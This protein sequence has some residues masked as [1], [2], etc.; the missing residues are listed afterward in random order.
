MKRNLM[1]LG[2]E[3]GV[4]KTTISI[5]LCRYLKKQKYNIVPFKSISICTEA[6]KNISGEYISVEQFMQAE[7]CEI[8]PKGVL[9]PVCIK[10]DSNKIFINGKFYR[11]K[12]NFKSD[13]LIEDFKSFIKEDFEKICEEYEYRIIE[14]N[15]ALSQNEYEYNFISNNFTTELTE[16]DIILVSDNE[17]GGAIPSLYGTLMLIDE[18]IKGKIKGIIINK[19]KD[20]TD[21][22]K[23]QI[24]DFEKYSNIPIL[25]VIPYKNIELDKEKTVIKKI[26]STK[27]SGLNIAIVKLDNISNLT[28]FYPLELEKNIN[29]RYVS[30]E[31]EIEGANLI[32]IPGSKSPINDLNKLK[33]SGMYNKII[34]LHKKGATVMGICS[35]FQMLGKNLI[36]TEDNLAIE[37]FDMIPFNTKFSLN[38]K[39][40]IAKGIVCSM[41]NKLKPLSNIRIYGYEIQNGYSEMLDG[42]EVFII[43]KNNNIV[44]LSN[45][46]GDVFGTYI[47]G[48][49]EIE[50]FRK[51]LINSLKEKYDVIIENSIEEKEKYKM[52]RLKQ[53]DTLTE[54]IENN[55]DLDKVKGFFSKESEEIENKDIELE[56]TKDK[57]EVR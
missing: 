31:S 44:G 13:E 49:F 1:F 7:A 10:E 24:R 39:T 38:K 48:I 18:N 2:T 22:L 55:I 20:T 32:I 42:G 8:E 50:A 27:R 25:G 14:G 34:D 30:S 3:S 29:I 43:D 35:G 4:G 51:N 12:E 57:E 47:H 54:L 41:D 21:S 19:N 53:Y 15:G 23:N 9:N 28:D 11:N 26:R 45:E 6:K 5:A 37:G 40:A 16:S 33:E 56:I 52:Y 46:S 17:R 36:S